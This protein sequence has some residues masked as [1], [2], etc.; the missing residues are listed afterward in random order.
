M[1]QNEVS[2]TAKPQCQPF[3]LISDSNAEVFAAFCVKLHTVEV[4]DCA[5]RCCVK[6]QQL[7][8]IADNTLVSMHQ[9]DLRHTVVRRKILFI[10]SDKMVL[11]VFLL[12]QPTSLRSSHIHRWREVRIKQLTAFFVERF[13]VT[14]FFDSFCWK[15]FQSLAKHLYAKKMRCASA[16]SRKKG[17]GGK[18]VVSLPKHS[19]VEKKEN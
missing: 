5:V 18:V 8:R 13:F 19:R 2:S 1:R 16:V 10:A 3:S 4:C 17:G 6:C 11:F 9:V 12:Q 14:F 7:I 15:W